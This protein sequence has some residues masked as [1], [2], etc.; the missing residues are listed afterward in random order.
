MSNYSRTS[1]RC[2]TSLIACAKLRTV[3]VPSLAILVAA[4]GAA[5]TYETIY[6]FKG[7]PD[8]SDPM[9]GLVIA[10][11]GALFGTTFAGGTSGQGTV[12]ELTYAKGTGWKE[13]VLHNFSGS[14]DGAN[15]ES[16]LAFGSTGALYG[17]TRTG[18]GGEG[19]IF[20]MVPPATAGGAWTETVLV[21]FGVSQSAIPNGPIL[22]DKGGTLYTTTQGVPSNGGNPLG[23]V[24]ALVPPA[25]Q[26]GAWTEYELY[27]F[28][29]PGGLSGETPTSGVVSVGGSLYGTTENAGADAW[30]TVY[31]LT[32]PTTHGGAWTETTIETFTGPPGD[33]GVPLAAL[34]AGPG[35]VLYGT[36]SGGGS[37]ICPR[38]EGGPSY[39]C[40]AVFQL[41]PPTVSSGTWIESVIY[42][43]TGTNGDGAFPAASVVIGKNGAL[44]GTTEFGGSAT[45][46]CPGSYY[47]LAGC[48]TVFKLTPPAAPGG[49]W[50]ETVLHDFTDA[51][52][53]GANPGA[54]LVLS[55]NGVLYGTSGGGTA[56]KGTIFAVAP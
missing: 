55:S 54:P 33:G 9:G 10:T 34:T 20:E 49:A 35:G 3:F 28:G 53:D 25:T 45:S 51:N 44:Y 16:T 15:P 11:N 48:G 6:S 41:T 38:P 13:T 30:G 17:T 23:L 42:S 22:I 8:G 7:S 52:G 39:G 36:T 50:T 31:G 56:G 26:G 2:V 5:Q 27:G 37:G 24:I 14:P 32:P 29:T 46:A 40:G 1:G 43:F 19:A 4:V 12:Y 18:G 21:G 47:V